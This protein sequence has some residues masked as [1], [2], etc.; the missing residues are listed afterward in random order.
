M[1]TFPPCSS[2]RRRIPPAATQQTQLSH[3]LISSLLDYAAAAACAHN[4]KAAAVK[5]DRYNGGCD[6]LLVFESIA[7]VA[8][9]EQIDALELSR[10]EI[11]AALARQTLLAEREDDSE[12]EAESDTYYSRPKIK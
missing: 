11:K 3:E 4:S 8:D 9:E 12:A 5:S 1:S 7:L 10:R 2:R 6:N